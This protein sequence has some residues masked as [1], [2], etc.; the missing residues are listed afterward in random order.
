MSLNSKID[1]NRA[2]PRAVRPRWQRWAVELL[3]L[4][5]IVGV[6]QWWQSRG[7][8]SGAAPQLAGELINGGH[9]DL[10]AG[11]DRPVLV[12]FWA[13]WC[14]ICRLEQGSIQALSQDY[15]VITVATTSGSA[16]EVRAFM[17]QQ[18][19]GFPVLLDEEG[20]MAREWGV[21]GV[22]ASF[23]IDPAGRV[24]HATVGYTS[25]IGLRVRLWLA[26]W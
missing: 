8:V 1:S 6:V 16:D 10:H 13:D 23:V 25:G 21:Q 14:P 11:L 18:G 15:R 9:V 17:R 7:V 12:H 3:I 22:P 4:L 19:L 5:L 2:A 20:T 26:A 24:A